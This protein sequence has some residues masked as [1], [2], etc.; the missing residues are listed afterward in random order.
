VQ[1]NTVSTEALLEAQR[2]PEKYW[3]LTAPRRTTSS[4]ARPKDFV[5]ERELVGKVVV[6][7]LHARAS[8]R[9]RGG[10]LQTAKYSSPQLR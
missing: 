4:G 3:D 5:D 8:K 2:H 7:L 6:R 9:A 10:L 1:F